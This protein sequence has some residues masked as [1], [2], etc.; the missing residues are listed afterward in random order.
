LVGPV[1]SLGDS[2]DRD[3][4]KQTGRPAQQAAVQPIMA[5]LRWRS[6]DRPASPYHQRQTVHPSASTAPVRPLLRSPPVVRS[7]HRRADAVAVRRQ[8]VASMTCGSRG[9][10]RFATAI[11]ARRG[12][13]NGE[14]PSLR[15]DLLV[16][17]PAAA[18]EATGLLRLF[19][20][21][22]LAFVVDLQ[23]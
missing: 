18:A 7:T 2:A 20:F 10:S 13:A 17:S 11:V 16:G 9:L 21:Q 6:P 14:A 1:P 22:F 23:S 8:D 15:K 12:L 4:D 19:E 5:R 3:G